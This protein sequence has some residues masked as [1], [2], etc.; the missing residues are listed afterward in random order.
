MSKYFSCSL[1]HKL[2]QN[3]HLLDCI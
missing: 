2:D 1:E 3:A